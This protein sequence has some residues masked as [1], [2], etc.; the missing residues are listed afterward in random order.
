V[1]RSPRLA[2]CCLAAVTGAAALAVPVV[3]ALDHAAPAPDRAATEDAVAELQDAAA[4]AVE[5]TRDPRSGGVDALTTRPGAPLPVDDEE[6]V[7]RYGDA[8]GAPGTDL[9][10]LSTT[11]GLAGTSAV[12]L[13]QQVDGVP[14]FGGQTSVQLDA[15]GR[16]SSALSDLSSTA[17][18]V[19]T[20]PTVTPAEATDQALAR[21]ARDAGLSVGRLRA[22][23]AERWIYDPAVVGADDPGG[24][25]LAWRVE[26]TGPE[27]D[28]V[29]LVDAAVGGAFLAMDQDAHAIQRFVCDAAGADDRNCNGGPYARTELTGTSPVPEVNQAFVAAGFTY[30]FFQQRFG[31]D[32]LDGNGL[33]LRATVRYCGSTCPYENAFWHGTAGEEGIVLGAGYATDD[34]V[35]HE[36]THGLVQ[37]TAGLFT[38]Y[39]SGAINESMADVFGELIDLTDGVDGSGGNVRWLIGEDRAAGAIRNMADPT[40]KN[41]PGSMTSPLYRGDAGDSGGTHANA[42]V[43]NRVA[44]LLTDGGTAGSTTISALGIDKVAAIYYQTLTTQLTS[45]SDYADLAHALPQACTDLVGTLGITLG[46][47]AQVEAAVGVVQMAVVPP[48]APAPEAPVC[49]DGITPA[50]LFTDDFENTASGKWTTDTAAGWHWSYP[51]P[52][53]QRYATSGDLNL[54]GP[55]TGTPASAPGGRNY[56]DASIRM[57]NAVNLPANTHPYL[58]FRH[59]WF[60]EQNG[61]VNYDGGVLEYATTSN[62]WTDAGPLFTDNGYNGTLNAPSSV[63]PLN[64]RSAFVDV[65]RG[66]VST[67]LDLSPL[68]NKNVRFRFRIGED[69]TG[70]DLG[71]YVDDVRIY[72]CPQPAVTV[73]QSA[74]QSAVTVGDDIDLH[75]TIA[76]TG[77]VPLTGVEVTDSDVPDCDGPVSDIAVGA[78]RTVDCRYSTVDPDDLG[79]FTNVA[80]V[81]ADQLSGTTASNPVSIPVLAPGTPLVL[82][83]QAVDQSSVGAGEPVDLHLTVT[84]IG[85][86]PLSGITLFDQKAPECAG[87]VTLP[88][89]ATELVVGGRHTVDCV[90]TPPGPGTWT[91]SAS[92]T[93]TELP[94]PTA[95]SDISV[96]VLD[97]TA[98]TVTVTSP[99]DGSVVNQGQL[100]MADYSCTDDQPAPVVTCDGPVD[101]GQPIDVTT[102]GA[103]AFTVTSTD[104]GGNETTVTND[105][106]VAVRRPDGRIRQ[107]VAGAT[108]GDGVYNTTGAGQRRTARVARGHSVVFFV[109]VQ[110]D[111]SHAE[112]LRVR[113]Q[114]STTNYTVAYATGGRDISRPMRTGSYTTPVMAPGAVRTI[115]VVVTVG[116]GAPRRSQVDRLVTT[117]STSDPTRKDVVRFIVRR[118]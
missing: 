59:A 36:L 58:W 95:A 86:V 5:L 90:H 74:D 80:T 13:Q 67:R 12:R 63:N 4:G 57:T 37:Y 105:Y 82:L 29:V 73:T 79:T 15:S 85:N 11:D 81:G 48:Q 104:A 68:A 64:G 60:F 34:I 69:A 23:P 35:G 47:C 6:F 112:A 42:G 45:A 114:P 94:D 89:G 99:A 106:V 20:D 77:N 44:A 66:Y 52:A 103:H 101:D 50:D 118:A 117:T 55:D 102:P 84:N 39:Q 40:T 19:G 113:G 65:S 21:V 93:T 83:Q 71:W 16:V 72:L 1:Q 24:A 78:T 25:R 54:W 22:G 115:K 97:L 17:V 53:S 27:L 111:G 70:Q 87:P 26:V 96:Q 88:G 10:P 18:D 92:V 9:V 116:R 8:L 91:N 30:L 100:V 43:G 2:L 76:N 46:D 75:L 61:G 110:N 33:S 32:S 49:P 109:T 56:G 62:N 38:Q 98:P 41:H 107:G 108:A 7:D 3:R 14:V 28:T 31:R 51:P